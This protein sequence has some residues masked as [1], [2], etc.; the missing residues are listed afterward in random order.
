[1]RG[2]ILACSVALL[3]AIAIAGVADGTWRTEPGDDGGYLEVTIGPCESDS[4]KTCGTISR[5][6]NKQGLDPQ[7]ENL[8]KLMI[9]GMETKDGNRYSGGTIWDPEEDKTYKSKM[10]VEGSKLDVDGCIA[11]ICQGQTW[12]RV[13]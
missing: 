8:G 3:P 11:F 5:A 4:S 1:M 7:Y 10:K 12:T 13:E 2:L 6:F 9:K